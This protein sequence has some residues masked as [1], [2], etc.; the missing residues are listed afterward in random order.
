MVG[1]ESFQSQARGRA[2]SW[3]RWPALLRHSAPRDLR[4]KLTVFL[5]PPPP[6]P[7]SVITP[8]QRAELDALIQSR[9]AAFQAAKP[10]AARGRQV[11]ATHC[12]SCH[13]HRRRRARWSARNS[14][15][16]ATAAPP[17]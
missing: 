2:R 9:L 5:P 4:E 6:A 11:F 17:A 13:A 7:P 16:S 3:P 15:A 8:E 1:V 10:D 12:A 14:K